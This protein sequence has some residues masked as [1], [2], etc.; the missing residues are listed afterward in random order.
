[1]AVLMV[2]LRHGDNHFKLESTSLLAVDV[3][4]IEA[5]VLVLLQLAPTVHMHLAR[6]TVSGRVPLQGL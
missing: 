4:D 5:G 2:G 3:P 1:M 6:H